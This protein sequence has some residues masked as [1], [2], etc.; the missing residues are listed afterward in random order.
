MSKALSIYDVI[1]YPVV[2]E[3]STDLKDQQNKYVFKV[4]V[5]ATKAEVKKSIEAIFKVTVTKVNTLNMSGKLKRFRGIT[6]RR[7]DYKKA[8]VSIAKDQK[9]DID[10]GV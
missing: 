5:H 4:D 9:I 3:K 10:A 6:A 8:V 7:V 2:T 1:R